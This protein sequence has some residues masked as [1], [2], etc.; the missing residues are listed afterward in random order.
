M[1]NG[2]KLKK[3]TAREDEKI[4]SVNNQAKKGEKKSGYNLCS[5]QT[6]EVSKFN[7]VAICSSFV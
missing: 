6:D 3:K 5:S 7:V 4:N 1:I 2:I